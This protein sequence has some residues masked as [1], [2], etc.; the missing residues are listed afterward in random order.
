MQ[1]LDWIVAIGLTVALAVGVDMASGRRGIIKHLLVSASGA[2]AGA[3]LGVRVFQTA[4]FNG[5]AWVGWTAMGA[6]LALAVFLLTRSK[7]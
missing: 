2:V 1:Y 4:T 5:W 6:A 3:F 7:R